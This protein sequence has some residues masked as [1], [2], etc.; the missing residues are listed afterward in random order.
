MPLD[1]A[2]CHR[3]AALAAVAAHVC[4]AAGL[5]ALRPAVVTSTAP[6]PLLVRWIVAAPT[7]L[8]RPIPFGPKVQP[9]SKP[10][11]NPVVLKR[12]QPEPAALLAAA[13]TVPAPQGQTAPAPQ[14]QDAGDTARQ[15][16]PAVPATAASSLIPAEAP[17]LPIAPPSFNADYLHNPPPKYP[18]LSRRLGEAGRVVLRV[19]VSTGG[20]AKR[21]ELRT[22]SGSR[23]LDGAAL[24]T[25]Q[26]WKFAPAR[27][28]DTPVAA[29]VL[30]PILFTLEG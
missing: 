22:S 15:A 28:G 6:E 11:A 4:A 27:Q 23:R 16:A 21:V 5:L 18:P 7:A 20:N 13:E 10:V 25:V 30:V 2:S 29:W 9:P 3:I 1:N 14:P 17:P 8:P 26:R 24:E 19:L 12:A